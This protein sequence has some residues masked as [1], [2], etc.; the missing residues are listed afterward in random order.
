MSTIEQIRRRA[1]IRRERWPQLAA[2]AAE[3]ESWELA[4]IV[5]RQAFGPDPAAGR[6]GPLPHALQAQS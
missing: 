1:T 4:N 2:L 5:P 6:T 3:L